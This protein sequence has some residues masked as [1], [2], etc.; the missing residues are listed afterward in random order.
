MTKVYSSYKDSDSIWLGD[1]PAHWETLRIR[2]CFR[3][4]TQKSEVTTFAVALE[5]IENWTG[6]FI[7]GETSFGSGGIAFDRGDILFGK[8]RPYLAKAWLADRSG[9]GVGDFFVM[10]PMENLRGQFAIYAVLTREFIAL[11]DGSTY[12]AKMPRASWD[13]VANVAFPIP[14]LPEQDKIIRFLD[15]ETAKIDALV[16]DQRR[17]IRLLKEKRQAVISHAVTKGLNPDAPMKDS[18]IEWLGEVPEHWDL[19]P[20]Y[21]LADFSSGKSHE[22]YLDD[23]GAHIYVSARFV[24]TQGDKPKFCSENLSPVKFGD[25]LMV[26]SDLPNGRALARAYQVQDHKSYAVNQRVCR[27]TNFKGDSRYYFYQ[28]DRNPGLLRYDDG[29]NQTHLSNAAYK[30]LF[31]CKPPLDEQEQIAT[32]LDEKVSLLDKL[33]SAAARDISILLERR[34]A[35]ISAAVTGKIDVRSSAEV[36]SFPMSQRKVRGLIATEIIIRNSRDRNFGRTKLHK[37][38]FLAEAFAGI[39]ELGGSY[40]RMTYGPLDEKMIEEMEAEAHAIAGITTEQPGGRDTIV[41]YTTNGACEEVR[42]ELCEV[43]G[44]ERIAKLDKLI[45][46]LKELKTREAEAVATLF[47]VWNDALIDGKRPNDDDIVFGFLNEWHPGKAKRFS[48]NNLYSW[49][50]WMRRHQ[51]VPSGIGPRTF[52]DRL[53]L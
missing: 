16:E 47:A 7:G 17:L 42:A 38:V 31:L 27:L 21:A 30:K 18:G 22:P 50:G 23:E 44:A 45:D 32:F 12:G 39:S 14:P 51:L 24:S 29:A 41:T 3:L 1:V 36:I 6:Q 40:V 15:H 9:E 10:R 26:M 35:L 43:L 53:P 28:L 20:L 46:D 49:L 5:N 48:K 52:S 33:H 25:V 2:H 13:Y 34:A 11:I 4:L 8:L 37:E 19:A